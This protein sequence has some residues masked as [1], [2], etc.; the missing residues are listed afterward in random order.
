MKKYIVLI[1]YFVFAIFLCG[2]GK[3]KPVVSDLQTIQQRGYLIVGTKNDSPPFGY[4]DGTT[5]VGIDIEIAKAIAQN[6]FHSTSPDTVEFVSV[7]PQNRISKLNSKQV[8]I[9]IATMSINDKRKLVID[10]SNP[11]F[12]ACQKI[13]VPID[14]KITHL[15]YFNTKGTLAVVL[16]TTGEKI[17]RL[18]A[19]NAHIVGAKS[20]TEAF[21]LLEGHFVDAILG[22]D[23]ILDGLN[24]GNYKVINRAYSKE[25]YAVA[26]RKG[27]KSKELLSLVNST[28]LALIDEKKL[29]FIKNSLLNN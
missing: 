12:V 19:P 14:S 24:N 11:Y 15:N 4:Y 29:N 13:I 6:I 26:L 21:E 16:G 28:I 27:E 1:I 20:Y 9:L 10:F 7:T 17:L 22:D 5:L 3:K 23:V 2:C 8:D 18:V 25:Y